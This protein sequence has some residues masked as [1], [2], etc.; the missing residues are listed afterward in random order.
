[1]KIRSIS[2]L[3]MCLFLLPGE[4]FAGGC[5]PGGFANRTSRLAPAPLQTANVIKVAPK[6]PQADLKI[7]QAV[8]QVTQQELKSVASKK[9]MHFNDVTDIEEGE[10]QQ[11]ALELVMAYYGNGNLEQS[12]YMKDVTQICEEARKYFSSIKPEGLI[13]FDIDDTLVTRYYDKY[14]SIL[15]SFN[16]H[17]KTNCT[18]KECY[19]K[20]CSH[21]DKDKPLALAPVKQLKEAVEKMGFKTALVSNMPHSMNATRLEDLQKAGYTVD[22]DNLHSIPDIDYEMLGV[23]YALNSN[24]EHFLPLFEFLRKKYNL[25]ETI[26]KEPAALIAGMKLAKRKKLAEK[27]TIVGNVGD[28]ETDFRGGHSGYEVRLPNYMLRA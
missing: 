25:A 20:K 9:P 22:P 4:L 12:Q 15:E 3:L 24:N 23:L 21:P 19:F 26:E 17:G 18:D 2:R 28:F 8:Q 16:A 1:M 7:A 13:V 10:D 14:F 5:C 27:Y 6:A 11:N